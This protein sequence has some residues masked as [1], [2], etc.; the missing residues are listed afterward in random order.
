MDNLSAQSAK[1][2]EGVRPP[3]S[4]RTGA[5]VFDDGIAV[6]NAVT[7]AKESNGERRRW[8]ARPGPRHARRLVYVRQSAAAKA[9][10][11]YPLDGL[12]YVG[13]FRN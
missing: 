13:N 8:L 1:W 10:P 12:R 7:Q 11:K 4:R 5:D 2:A 9:A 3:T 6:R